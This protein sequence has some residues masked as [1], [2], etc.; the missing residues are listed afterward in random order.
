MSSHGWGKEKEASTHDYGR[1]SY[2]DTGMRVEKGAPTGQQKTPAEGKKT[3]GNSFE[4]TSRAPVNAN[5]KL[6]KNVMPLTAQVAGRALG[7]KNDTTQKMITI[8]ADTGNPKS[9]GQTMKTIYPNL[10]CV[11]KLIRLRQGFRISKSLKGPVCRSTQK[12][13]TER[14]TQTIT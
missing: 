9:I 1:M 8:R 11:R 5:K 2:H 12:R 6:K 3:L 4:A 7:T 14:E 10:G 13:M